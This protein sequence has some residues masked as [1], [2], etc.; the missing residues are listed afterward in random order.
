[1][2]MI[3]IMKLIVICHICFMMKCTV[4]TLCISV[5]HA[6]IVCIPSAFLG[7]IHN[8]RLGVVGVGVCQNWLPPKKITPAPQEYMEYMGNKS[9]PPNPHDTV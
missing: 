7:S 9:P 8:L 3:L 5:H 2:K 6:F 4:R 1:M